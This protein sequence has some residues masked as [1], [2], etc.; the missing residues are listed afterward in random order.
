MLVGFGKAGC[1]VTDHR[2]YLRREG[3]CQQLS[4]QWNLQKVEHRVF[5]MRPFLRETEILTKVLAPLFPNS[6]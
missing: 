4:R 2:K 3:E 6:W 5:A 1:V